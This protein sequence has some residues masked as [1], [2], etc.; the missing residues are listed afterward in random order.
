MDGFW[1]CALAFLAVCLALEVISAAFRMPPANTRAYWA[2]IDRQYKD[3]PR[4]K[5]TPAAGKPRN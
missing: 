2:S 5:P 1:W 3:Y 4:A